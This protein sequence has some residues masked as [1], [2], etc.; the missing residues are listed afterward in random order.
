M[1][2]GIPKNTYEEVR[3]IYKDV[4][5]DKTPYDRYYSRNIALIVID[6]FLKVCCGILSNTFKRVLFTIKLFDRKSCFAGEKEILKEKPT[7]FFLKE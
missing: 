2:V 3:V 7:R 1:L 5:R 4:L 6:E